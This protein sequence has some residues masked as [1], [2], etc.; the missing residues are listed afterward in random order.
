MDGSQ[1]SKNGFV[2]VKIEF[3]KNGE[4]FQETQM[5]SFGGDVT[6]KSTGNWELSDTKLKIKFGESEK[7]C[8]VQKMKEQIQFKPDPLFK[9]EA[10]KTTLYKKVSNYK[11][12]NSETIFYH[13]DDYRQ[14]EIVPK[15]NLS[16]LLKEADNIEE[17]S[18]ENFE[19]TGFKNIYVR[20]EETFN[21]ID[22]KIYKV[23][24]E[25][26]L[27][28][29]PIKKYETVSTGIRPGEMLS[30]E[31]IGY[32]KNYNGIFFQFENEVVSAI[33]IAGR[34]MNDDESV[35]EILKRIGQKWELLLMDWNS[36]KLID[37]KNEL[38]I[39]NYLIKN[40][41]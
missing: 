41:L 40:E 23:E 17:F 32:G 3:R 15:E 38:Q 7:E 35:F 30:K 24:L 33:W 9:E 26:I 21:L 2:S 31:T 16:E 27:D 39:E 1:I 37:L 6:T 34:I 5:K 22:K 36:L 14:V 18:S 11:K 10:I 20:G 4:A 28:D 8:T 29:F 19:G 25:K 13:E 12:A